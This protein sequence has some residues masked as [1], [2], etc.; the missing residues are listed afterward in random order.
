M[1]TYDM[2]D[3]ILSL[4]DV[5]DN[6][7][8]D[9]TPRWRRRE[10]PNIEMYESGDDLEI[11]ALVPGLSASEIELHLV[12]DSLIIEG[13]KKNDYANQ[14][15]IRKERHFGAFKRSVKL[16]FRVDPGRIV[17][18]L[19]NGILLVRLNKSEDAKPKKIEIK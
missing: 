12:D 13:E 18:E 10:F 8:S 4:R 7:F 15:Y 16:P 3:D 6:F 5:V 2:I 1:Y 9:A 11:R 19:K 17:A 14:P